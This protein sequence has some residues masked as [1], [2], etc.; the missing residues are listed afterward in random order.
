MRKAGKPVENLA[1]NDRA[2]HYPV[3]RTEHRKLRF[4]TRVLAHEVGN[5]VGVQQEEQGC[6]LRVLG[7]EQSFRVR[8][9]F[10]SLD[11]AFQLIDITGSEIGQS[12]HG[13]QDGLG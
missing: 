12:A 11:H 4:N 6:S 10:A 8:G 9:Q 13:L 7:V 5:S 1:P 2:D 3:V